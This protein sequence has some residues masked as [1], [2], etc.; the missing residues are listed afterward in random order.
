MSDNLGTWTRVRIRVS[1]AWRAVIL[2]WHLQSPYTQK[3]VWSQNQS[4]GLLPAFDSNSR[5][6]S[7]IFIF[8]VGRFPS[9]RQ[10]DLPWRLVKKTDCFWLVGW[11]E[12]YHSRHK[13][14]RDVTWLRC[15]APHSVYWSWGFPS[16]AHVTQAVT[17]VA[18]VSV[19]PVLIWDSHRQVLFNPKLIAYWTP[20][21]IGNTPSLHL[22]GTLFE[23]KP[24]PCH[25]RYLLYV[26]TCN[27]I[28]N[29]KIMS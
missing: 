21:L 1:T 23:S 14:G 27:S 18:F 11:V 3:T 10:V 24:T 25:L 8:Q 17:R 15:N 19:L 20:T 16:P 13:A 26:F 22:K 28:R 4:V 7:A 12:L 29:T 5:L 6:M 9:P 2:S